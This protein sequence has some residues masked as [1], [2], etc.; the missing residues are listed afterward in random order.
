MITL[1]T[2]II[3]LGF[4]TLYNTSKK[5]PLLLSNHLEKWAHSHPGPAKAIGLLLLSLGMLI[6]MFDSGVGA[7]MFTFLVILMTVASLV[8]VVTPLKFVGYRSLLVL[9][10]ISLMLEFL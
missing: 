6:A 10:A 5:A 4:Y 2:L 9:F 3:F 7:G 8:V 1:A